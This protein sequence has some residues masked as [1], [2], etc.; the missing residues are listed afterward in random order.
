M[1]IA[2]S[3][4]A[5]WHSAYQ[6]VRPRGGRE[7]TMLRTQGF[8]QVRCAWEREAWTFF[9]SSRNALCSRR[10]EGMTATRSICLTHYCGKTSWFRVERSKANS[11]VIPLGESGT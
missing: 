6:F 10:V 2:G 1:N 8:H 5:S 7:K 4:M 11:C 3:R 9:F